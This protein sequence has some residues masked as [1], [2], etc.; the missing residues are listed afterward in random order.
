MSFWSKLWGNATSKQSPLESMVGL[1]MSVIAADGEVHP[2]E[3]ARL[4]SI[5]GRRG[6]FDSISRHE[7]D[8]LVRSVG[9]RARHQPLQELISRAASALSM[10][11]RVMCFALCL[12]LVMADGRVAPEERTLM[13]AV[14][15]GFGLPAET[16]RSLWSGAEQGA[17]LM[18]MSGRELKFAV[19][20][21][22]AS[23]QEVAVGAAP[24]G[25]VAWLTRGA[26]RVP[27]IIGDREPP[28]M[29]R[30]RIRV[31]TERLAAVGD[32]EPQLPPPGAS[33]P[34]YLAVL[35]LDLGLRQG[36]VDLGRACL[37]QAAAEVAPTHHSASEAEIHSLMERILRREL[38]S[39]FEL[40]ERILS[41]LRGRLSPSEAART[42][43]EHAV[44]AFGNVPPPD[45]LA[46]AIELKNRG[47][48]PAALEILERVLAAEPARA[49][50][51]FHKAD[52]LDNLERLDEALEAYDKALQLNP[53]HVRALCDKGHVLNKLGRRAEAMA[54]WQ[55]ALLADPDN[56]FGLFNLGSA[57]FQTGHLAEAV[58]RLTRFLHLQPRMPAQE[59]LARDLLASVENPEA[60][61]AL[62]SRFPPTIALEICGYGLSRWPDH[63]DLTLRQGTSLEKLER[64]GEAL[65]VYGRLNQLHPAYAQGWL[66]MGLCLAR[67]NRLQEALECLQRPVPA[68]NRAMEAHRDFVLAGVLGELGRTA[69][70]MERYRQAAPHSPAARLA[71]GWLHWESGLFH[72]ALEQAEALLAGSPE[73]PGARS[74]KGA[75]LLQLGRPA[76]A[77][78][79]LEGPDLGRCLD[80]LGRPD[81]ARAAFERVSPMDGRRWLFEAMLEERV[82][83]NEVAADYYGR[84]LECLTAHRRV[85]PMGP[86][87]SG[88]LEQARQGLARLDPRRLE[89]VEEFDRQRRTKAGVGR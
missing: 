10:E 68:P 43:E 49:D 81:E 1:F 84:A 48:N 72:E 76:E 78:G 30:Q 32:L 86:V 50:A 53:G 60:L 58:E 80:L 71:L 55:A 7:Y 82:G 27:L 39:A 22:R 54:A 21:G 61:D 64:H 45:V 2:D 42:L 20:P 83:R 47:E 77:E 9:Q 73:H 65:K 25:G 14:Q 35:G 31:A 38:P 11:Q 26:G 79:L 52:A 29:A 44:R 36:N 59:Q 19:P 75:S 34:G 37:Q 62:A 56:P 89:A 17:E 5:L 46:G 41:G 28:E 15:L 23:G 13:A 66:Q 8:R 88:E 57:L 16:A 6:L 63:P 40:C 51:W 67:L 33:T 4:G 70:A 74:L 12:E 24:Q 3:V 69:E 87:R 18:E 85:R